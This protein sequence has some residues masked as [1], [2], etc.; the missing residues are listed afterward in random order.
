MAKT[1]TPIPFIELAKH[2]G[3]VVTGRLSEDA[4]QSQFFLVQGVSKTEATLRLVVWTTKKQGKNVVKTG[5]LSRQ[6]PRTIEAKDYSALKFYPLGLYP[7]EK[8]NADLQRLQRDA[9]KA[10]ASEQ[11]A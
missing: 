3:T 6:A 8:P 7:F 9:A 1:Y 11:S 5:K 10:A 2:I 4:K